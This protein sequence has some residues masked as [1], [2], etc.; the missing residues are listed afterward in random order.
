MVGVASLSSNWLVRSLARVY[1]EVFRNVPLL[2]QLLFWYSAVILKLPP[3]RQS[4]E[5]F[6]SFF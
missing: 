2:L 5:V 1:V 4:V 3:I 6:R